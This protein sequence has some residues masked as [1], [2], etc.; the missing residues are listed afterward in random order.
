[1]LSWGKSFVSIV[2]ATSP[3]TSMLGQLIMVSGT[4][5]PRA[6]SIR[7]IYFFDY[8]VTDRMGPA[9]AIKFILYIYTVILILLLVSFKTS[10][11]ME[12]IL[13]FIL[14]IVT[15]VGGVSA[16]ALFWYD[17]VGVYKYIS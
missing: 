2:M 7:S 3:F 13:C 6:M 5:I 15:T 11:V 1:M 14:S 16:N 10:L 9:V 12:T 17:V 4:F 8:I